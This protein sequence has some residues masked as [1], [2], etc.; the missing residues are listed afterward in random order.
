M[1]KSL[2]LFT[3]FT[4][5]IAKYSPIDELD[6]KSY[7]GEWKQI[8]GNKFDETFQGKGKC[9]KAFYKLN[10]ENVSVY[11]TQLDE[12]NNKQDITGYAYYKNG[13]KGGDLTVKLNN[14][15]E[16][17]YWVIEIGP[18]FDNLY[19]YSIVSDNYKLSLFVLA[20]NVTRFF[21][22]YNDKVLDSLKNFG[23]VKFYNKPIEI[24]QEGC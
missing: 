18:I 23:F 4:L 3:L 24:D 2:I 14:T 13:S 21:E 7:V 17:P 10:N 19:D 15:P 6:L 1:F 16:A 11:N 20:R 9:V 5:V 12:N 22:Y 8:Y